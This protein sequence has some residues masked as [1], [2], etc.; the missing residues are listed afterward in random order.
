M[1]GETKGKGVVAWEDFQAM[2]F[3]R[4]DDLANL[5]P[6][7]VRVER[8]ISAAVAAAK[9]NP[10]LLFADQ[11][12]LFNALTKAAQDGLLPDGREAH[13]NIYNTNLAKRGESDNW[14]KMAQYNPMVYGLRKRAMELASII[15]DAQV[16]HAGDK[17][18][19]EMGDNPHIVH[20]P[21]KM[22]E[23]RGDMVGAYAIFRDSH[24]TILHRERM[25][26]IEI[27]K[28]R[29]QSKNPDGLMWK[30]F[31]S[32]GWRK[33]VIRRGIKTVPVSEDFER[34]VRRED[35]NFDF[36]ED[37]N[38]TAAPA[39]IP[40]T[41]PEPPAITQQGEGQVIPP[42]NQGEKQTII[43]E[44][45]AAKKPRRKKGEPRAEDAK[46]PAGQDPI[47]T[48]QTEPEPPLDGSAM[49]DEDYLQFRRAAYNELQGCENQA[50]V[51][52]VKQR[53]VPELNLEDRRGFQEACADR[54]TEIW[55]RDNKRK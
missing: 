45:T 37:N 48:A 40:P 1:S 55:M 7:N 46:I 50:A 21:A 33:T 34:I 2:L 47:N 53:L 36:S 16:V 51:D 38:K 22:G 18:D 20:K 14:V 10:D 23:P 28:V 26:K 15:I 35:E 8:F 52:D 11:R 19:E 4:K 5:L 17:F 25:D 6:S 32:E 9:H 49:A 30:K 39:L 44:G 3:E 13:I 24:Q 41:P 43:V 12:S 31:A 27:E 29:E 54:A 42:I